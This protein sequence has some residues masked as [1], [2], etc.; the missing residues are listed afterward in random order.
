[1]E[2]G[3]DR[4]VR[5]LDRRLRFHVLDSKVGWLT[6]LPPR[7]PPVLEVLLRPVEKTEYIYESKSSS[8]INAIDPDKMLN[9]WQNRFVDQLE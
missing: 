5:L 8:D 9:C 6:S 7:K 2:H 3:T 1:M 4:L